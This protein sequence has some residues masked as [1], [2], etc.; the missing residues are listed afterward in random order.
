[1]KKLLVV[2]LILLSSCAKE[3][4]LKEGA[5]ILQN[6]GALLPCAMD[7]KDGKFSFPPELVMSAVY[8]H[9]Y[10]LVGNKLTIYGYNDKEYHYELVDD[11]TLK[12]IS[13]K[14]HEIKDNNATYIYRE[15]YFYFNRRK[16]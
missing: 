10:S 12:L 16:P 3:Y 6:E 2:I 4:T 8:E 1:M 9:D 13:T 15:N 7:F 5:Y 14:N 11:N